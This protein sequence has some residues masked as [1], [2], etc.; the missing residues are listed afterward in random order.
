[1]SRAQG[2]AELTELGEHWQRWA[3]VVAHFSNGRKRKHPISGNAYRQLHGALLQSCKAAVNAVDESKLPSLQRIESLVRPWVTVE[4]LAGAGTKNAQRLLGQCQQ[5]NGVFQGVPA[6]S[7][8]GGA[9]VGASPKAGLPIL[10]LAFIIGIGITLIALNWDQLSAQVSPKYDTQLWVVWLKFNLRH[11]G[12][13]KV[14]SIV[15]VVTVALG[16]LLLYATKKS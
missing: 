11:L 3:A 10:L 16:G 15:T 13:F 12:F 6:K 14:F 4:A 2:T 8:A 1:M 7:R 9:A 5:V